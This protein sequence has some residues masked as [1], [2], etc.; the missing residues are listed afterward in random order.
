VAVEK[1]VHRSRKRN[2]VLHDIRPPLRNRPD[3]RRLNFRLTAAIDYLEARDC[4]AI[5]IRRAD[6]M[7]KTH[8]ANLAVDQNLLDAPLLLGC[9]RMQE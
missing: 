3:V 1:P 2:P 8:I 6:L 5:L 9:W 4:A 7:A